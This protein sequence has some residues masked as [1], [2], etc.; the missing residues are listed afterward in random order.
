MSLASDIRQALADDIAVAS[1]GPVMTAALEEHDLRPDIVPPHP[2]M[3][4]LVR[5]AAEEAARVLAVKRASKP[6]LA[7]QPAS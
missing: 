4:V 2:K 7:G 3:G 6:T 5:V 1:V